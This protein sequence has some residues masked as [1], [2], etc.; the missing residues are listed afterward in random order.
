MT[1]KPNTTNIEN[2]VSKEIKKY[3]PKIDLVVIVMPLVLLCFAGCVLLY[4]FLFTTIYSDIILESVLKEIFV[5]IQRLSILGIILL[6]FVVTIGVNKAIESK[7]YYFT[8]LLKLSN[9]HRPVVYITN[10]LFSAFMGLVIRMII[11]NK[12]VLVLLFILLCVFYIFQI[13]EIC[14]QETPFYWYVKLFL[15]LYDEIGR[16]VT[17]IIYAILI[18]ILIELFKNK[19]S[20]YVAFFFLSFSFGL[21]AYLK[22]LLRRNI[23]KNS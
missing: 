4:S 2:A 1:S 8:E 16:L 14:L 10:G 15:G 22:N 13:L 12:N 11:M 3:L 17:L 19:G 20:L 21:I 6:F 18:V 7:E 23:S 9:E 5:R